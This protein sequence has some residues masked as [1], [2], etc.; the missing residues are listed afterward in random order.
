MPITKYGKNYSKTTRGLWNYYR[1]EPD[2]GAVG[3]INY[4]IKDSES[5]DY[6]TSISGGL[7]VTI[8]K[9]K[10]RLLYQ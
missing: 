9:K 5:F 8:Q 7:E 3:D 6:Q 4:S 10:L 2:S 1:D